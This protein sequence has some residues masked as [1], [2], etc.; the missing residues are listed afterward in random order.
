MTEYDILSNID[1]CKSNLDILTYFNNT[2]QD[3]VDF[4]KCYIE[5]DKVIRKNKNE[6][7]SQIDVN[8]IV[9][10]RVKK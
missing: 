6:E 10:R 1:Q 2:K 8:N 9:R 3:F 5:I 4:V 7:V